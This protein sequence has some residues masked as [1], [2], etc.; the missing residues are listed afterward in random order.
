MKLPPTLAELQQE[1]VVMELECI[2][3]MYLNA[4]VPQLT[5]EGGIAAFC[6][7]YLE[8]HFASTNAAVARTKTFLAAINEFVRREGVELVRFRK[9]ERKDEVMQKKL[10]RFK[11]TGRGESANLSGIPLLERLLP[12]LASHWSGREDL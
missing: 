6:H 9:G 1:H 12:E 2:D 7:D 4:Y 10:R 11:K 8:H 3:R 5:S